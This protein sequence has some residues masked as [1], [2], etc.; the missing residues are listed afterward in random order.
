MG[1]LFF[2]PL[3]LSPFFPLCHFY[4]ADTT[5]I[6]ITQSAHDVAYGGVVLTGCDRAQVAEAMEGELARLS[7]DV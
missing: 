7:H 1:Y 2:L 6:I 5:V 4:N 3:S